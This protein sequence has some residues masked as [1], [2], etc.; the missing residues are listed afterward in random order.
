[1]L[2]PAITH[3]PSRALWLLL[4]Q[5][6]LAAAP[7]LVAG[8]AP[9]FE[10]LLQ[11]RRGVALAREE[12]VDWFWPEVQRQA[13]HYARRGGPEEELVA[14]GALAL[15]EAA[16]QYD[17]RRHETS[18]DAYVKNQVHRRI[19]RAYRRAMGYTGARVVP[20]ERAEEL[21]AA[22]APLIAV[23][24][25]LDLE[26]AQASLSPADQAVLQRWLPVAGA[27]PKQ[28]ARQLARRHGGTPAAWKKRLQRTRQRLQRW[29]QG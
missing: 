26:R 6:R 22:G 29:L 23:E 20:L 27:G 7:R 1:M 12:Y 5:M 17:P 13:R 16:F 19:R 9:G 14:E 21:P 18:V 25:R 10:T 2:A 24:A 11:L 4:Q 8:Q 15:W 3:R 28:A